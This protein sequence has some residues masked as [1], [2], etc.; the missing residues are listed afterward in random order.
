MRGFPFAGNDDGANTQVGEGVVDGS[1]AVP[2]VG[3]HVARCATGPVF[4]PLDCWNQLW[5]VSGVSRLHIVF[6][7]DPVVVV[8]ALP[9]VTE[10]DRFPQPALRHRPRGRPPGSL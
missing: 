3:G 4:H 7:N 6:E 5:C 10:L 9:F 1:V 8:D 2:A